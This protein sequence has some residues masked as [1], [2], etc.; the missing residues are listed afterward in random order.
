MSSEQFGRRSRRSYGQFL[1]A[2]QLLWYSTRRTKGFTG[3]VTPE[4]E[5]MLEGV[6]RLS[7]NTVSQKIRKIYQILRKE[8]GLVLTPS[9]LPDS[10]TTNTGNMS[11]QA[12][13]PVSGFNLTALPVEITDLIIQ[14]MH[15]TT[16]VSFLRVSKAFLETTAVTLYL[17][18]HFASTYRFAQFTWIV[19]HKPELAEMVEELD[20]S[21]ITED[22]TLKGRLLPCA[23]WR[24]F[25]YQE[26]SNTP[27]PSCLSYRG[28][29]ILPKQ[30]SHPLPAL[31][32]YAT[33][34]DVPIGGIIHILAA[35]PNIKSVS[36]GFVFGDGTNEEQKSRFEQPGTGCRLLD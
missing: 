22:N 3:C 5:D 15:Q 13:G 6:F 17:A 9:A 19:A 29:R 16:L 7:N 2:V 24:D 23:G 21:Y 8:T 26:S 34:R 33:A 10:N 35:C 1:E 30:S 18:P 11:L 36:S 32:N 12:K 27:A 20:L 25:K 28:L 14:H 4:T 31:R